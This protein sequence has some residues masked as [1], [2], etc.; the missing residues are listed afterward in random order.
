MGTDSTRCP[1]GSKASRFHGKAKDA[2][3]RIIGAFRSGT[4][5]KALAPIFINRPDEDTPWRKWSW[6]N[7]LLTALAGYSDARGFR[8]WQSVGRNVRKGQK[9]FQ[10]LAPLT[11]KVERTEHW[12]L[13]V[14]A[15]QG[16]EGRP[17]GGYRRGQAIAVGVENLTTWA[18]ELCHAADFK[19][20]GL[21]EL[22]QHWRSETV[23]ELGASILLECL[24][25]PID[26]DRGGCWRYVKAYADAAEIEP[27]KA[28]QR[29]LGRTCDAVALI[30]DTAAELA[31]VESVEA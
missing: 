24:G 10:I 22:G 13:S 2:A 19:T 15:F 5:P 9:S 20:G 21:T 25:H 12:G 29:V 11:K 4:L 7:Q 23:A 28:C 17:Q 6:S 3:D 8:Q 27:I 14:E 16:G 30:L 26:A 18:H 31:S 1:S